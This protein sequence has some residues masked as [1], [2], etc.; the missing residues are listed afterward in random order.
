MTEPRHDQNGGAHEFRG[1]LANPEPEAEPAPELWPRSHEAAPAPF[2]EAEPW[3]RDSDTW[4]RDP[5]AAVENWTPAR[6]PQVA[7]AE[8]WTPAR[9]PTEPTEPTWLRDHT[10][11]P[12]PLTDLERPLT[13]RDVTGYTTSGVP[14]VRR[15]SGAAVTCRGL[16][17][18][19]RLEGYD[20]VALSGVDLDIAPGESVAL[21]GPSGAGKSTLLSLL[22]GL[23]SPAAGRL[24]VGA[25]DL[26]KAT[27]VE[28]QRM[29]ATDI[30]VILQGAARNLLPYLTAEQNIHFAQGGAARQNRGQLPKPKELLSLVGMS[31]RRAR[32]KPS[33]M[34]PGERQRLALAV[35]IA[36]GAGLLL[37]DEPTS[38]LD[39]RSR[40]EMLRA[41]DAVN[42]AGTTVVVV[43]HDPEVGAQM[44]RTV[45]IRDGRVG[46]EGLRGEDFAVIGRDGSLHLP[47]E[48]LEVYA[49]GTLMR[50]ELQPDGTVRLNAMT[51]PQE[52]L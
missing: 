21:V 6:E 46:A 7:P 32:L 43:T 41:L 16:V 22:A 4:P 31:G 11:P 33:E 26:A 14:L 24:E 30:G 36:N 34:T 44:G 19:Y 27:E 23:I 15:V 5:A 13:R 39:A 40:D 29:R 12:P 42:R 18:I 25:H 1:W 38:Q 48:V 9:R 50:V 3:G 52:D 17:Y 47:P 45:T 28:L 37:A 49:P 8:P 20:V 51:P 2:R 10:A 35:G